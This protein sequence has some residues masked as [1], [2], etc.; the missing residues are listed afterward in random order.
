[1]FT[2]LARFP[3]FLIENLKKKVEN[4]KWK[5]RKKKKGNDPA[6]M[7]SCVRFVDS[8]DDLLG[9]CVDFLWRIGGALWMNILW[10][11]AWS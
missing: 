2:A 6:M 9:L 5:K 10:D 4:W 7:I 11:I 1:M 3:A 8:V